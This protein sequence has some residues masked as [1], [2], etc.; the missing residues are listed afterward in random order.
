MVKLVF[1]LQMTDGGKQDVF[2][3][4][5]EAAELHNLLVHPSHVGEDDVIPGEA[6]RKYRELWSKYT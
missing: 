5:D 1:F 2:L 3:S 6:G 4:L